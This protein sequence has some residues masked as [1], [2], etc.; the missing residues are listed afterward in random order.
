MRWS[1]CSLQQW[2]A[3][4]F[5]SAGGQEDSPLSALHG[6]SFPPTSPELWSLEQRWSS[7][8]QTG[9]AANS[10]WTSQDLTLPFLCPAVHQLRFLLQ[11]TP[12]LRKTLPALSVLLHMHIFC[13][14]YVVTIIVF[15]SFLTFWFLLFYHFITVIIFV[16]LVLPHQW[17]FF[18]ACSVVQLSDCDQAISPADQ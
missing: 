5:M 16:F 4:I 10:Q 3:G 18:P 9:P 17:F 15:G 1:R 11:M 2:V 13:T 7:F 14:A 8:H 12:S 6:Q